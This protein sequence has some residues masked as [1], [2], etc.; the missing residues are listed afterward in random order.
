M[1]NWFP[2][3]LQAFDTRTYP[4]QLKPLAVHGNESVQA[5]C[6]YYTSLLTAEE[7]AAI[8]SEFQNLK[9][10]YSMTGSG[11]PLGFLIDILKVGTQKCQIIGPFCKLKHTP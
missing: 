4:S 3:Y 9:V 8:P 6:D 10:R 2:F 7:R 1:F 5:L 11:H